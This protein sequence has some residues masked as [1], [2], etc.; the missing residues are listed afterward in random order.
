MY[1]V[2][3]FSI[4]DDCM[5]IVNAVYAIFGGNTNIYMINSVV[6]DFILLTSEMPWFQLKLVMSSLPY[7]IVFYALEAQRI[8][9]TI[10]GTDS[11]LV[12]F[13]VLLMQRQSPAA[14]LSVPFVVHLLSPIPN[15]YII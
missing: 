3:L 5:N 7:N 2:K 8:P 10:I 1:D 11:G 14:S 4:Q 9:S 6:F 13:N 15:C 12:S